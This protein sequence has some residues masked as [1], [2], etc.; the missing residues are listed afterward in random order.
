MMLKMYLEKHHFVER[1]ATEDEVIK[2][3]LSLLQKKLIRTKM[4]ENKRL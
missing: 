2:K 4:R 1:V 3:Q